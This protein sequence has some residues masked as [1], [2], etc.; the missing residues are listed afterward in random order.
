MFLHPVLRFQFSVPPGFHLV[1]GTDRVTSIY[2]GG[3]RIIFALDDQPRPLSMTR[4]LATEF[5]PG[6][7]LFAVESIVVNGMEGA[8][9]LL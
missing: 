6:S 7:R 5:A 2:P 8:T 3:A 9:G 1:S 4:Y